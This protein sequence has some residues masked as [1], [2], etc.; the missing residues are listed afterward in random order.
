MLMVQHG[1]PRGDEL[2]ADAHREDDV[3]EMA[4]V[5]VPELAPPDAEL[6]EARTV[7]GDRHVGPGRDLLRDAFSDCQRESPRSPAS[8]PRA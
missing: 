3:R 1:P 5:Q 2:L 8:S 4:A 6:D 7:R